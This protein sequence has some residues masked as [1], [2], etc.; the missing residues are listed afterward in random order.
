[1]VIGAMAAGYACAA[2]PVVIDD[3]E[4]G[5]GRWYAVDGNRDKGLPPLVRMTAVDEAK[6]GAAAARLQFDAAPQSWGHMQMNVRTVEWVARGCDRISLWVKGD[7]SGE[8][9]NLMFGNYER[10]PALCFI[11]PITL[12]F[13]GWKQ[14]VAPF[15][16]FKPEG[17]AARLNDIVLIQLNASGTKKPIDILVDEILA[18]P[19]ESGGKP[20]SFF[21]LDVPTTPGWDLPAPK[22]PVT[23]DPLTG[24]PAGMAIPRTLH[25]VRNHLDLHDPYEFAVDYPEPG[26][27]GVQV[28]TTSGYGGSALIISVDGQ[29][30][31]NKPFPG[32]TQTELTQYQ[33]YYSVPVPAGRHVIRVDNNGADWVQVDALR[34][35]N[36]GRG[37][38][39]VGRNDER[40]TVSILGPDGKGQA[41]VEAEVTVAGRAV[42]VARGADGLLRTAALRG[43]FPTGLYPIEATA[44][45]DGKVI[46]HATTTTQIGSPRVQP[47]RVAFR[48]GE[49]VQVR[50]RYV[51][52][53][54]VSAPGARL[55]VQIGRVGDAKHEPMVLT[56]GTDGLISAALGKRPAGAYEITIDAK[57]GLDHR[58]RVLVYDPASTEI[59]REGVIRLGKNERFVVGDG[60]DFTPW[61]FATIGLF[62]PSV[63]SVQGV[64]AWAYAP[65]EAVLNWIGLLR[66]Y[67]VNVVR[68]G[69]NVDN[70]KADQGGH[71]SPDIAARLRHFLDL[72]GSL[73][74]RG[75]PVMW[76]GHYHNFSFDGIK[77][78]DDLIKTQADWFTKPEAL[79]LQKQYVREVVGPYAGDA[80][81]FA[82]EV[83]NETYT[84]G[85]DRQA[86]IRWTNAIVDTM[87]EVDKSHLITISACEATP[88][89]EIEWIEG[90]KIDFFN[91][92]AYPTYMDYGDYRKQAG[93][94]SIREMGNYAAMMAAADAGH[95]KTV[96]LGETGNDRGQEVD[97]PE[98]KT[99][100]TR[101]CLWMA[102]LNGSPGGISWDAIADPREFDV[103]SRIVAQFD[104]TTWG[105][106][107]PDIAVHVE[108]NQDYRRDLGNLAK[109]TWWGLAHCLR[110]GF[111]GSWSN[112]G[113]PPSATFEPPQRSGFFLTCSP[114]YQGAF[115][116]SWYGQ[117]FIAYIRNVG[118]ILP[119]NVRTRTPKPLQVALGAHK[120]TLDVWDLDER[121]IVKT[122]QGDGPRTI[123]L[124]MT[125]HDFAL[126]VHGKK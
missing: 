15:R 77:A 110:C 70:M 102:F 58:F 13:T 92:H 23:V 104:W 46:Y 66:S 65:D 64:G 31:L 112:E 106:D 93:N 96:I 57:D 49:D 44:T 10:Q 82:W 107:L 17:L 69:V 24:V 116:N 22:G 19:A 55:T 38:V 122:V 56:E 80:R 114:G 125:D 118:G 115:I 79:A 71:L 117:G 113:G 1:M 42:P 39:S 16:E 59:A 119:Q 25:G 124:G 32:E 83:M 111:V 52:S 89:E 12:D 60:H 35:G 87:H 21:D 72:I 76:W 100:I 120:G 8:T 68:F 74:V 14:F 86:A 2:E 9:L 73:G 95:G 7:G 51:N 36:Y 48:A 85:G 94:D 30:K 27:F 3:F 84:A 54:G 5:V 97:Y 26:S 67:G 47:E 123:D 62:A 50:F 81:I 121:K 6:E 101:D 61:G 37:R 18:L 99:L 105:H 75:L 103:I 28:A 91:W 45:R 53:A 63:E 109:Y 108:N 29:E 40:V 98:F 4:S 126:V 20:G 34:F 41:G 78:Y 33:G 43:R 88:A 90:A 11:Y